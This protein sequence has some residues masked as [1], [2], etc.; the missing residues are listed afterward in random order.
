MLG[1]HSQAKW[2][3]FFFNEEISQKSSVSMAQHYSAFVAIL[4]K[5]KTELRMR[6]GAPYC[7]HAPSVT[8]RQGENS[9]E[10]QSLQQLYRRLSTEVVRMWNSI[11]IKNISIK[12]TGVQFPI[13]AVRLH[14]KTKF[15]QWFS[16]LGLPWKL[17]R[18][19]LCAS[20]PVIFVKE[21]RE[22]CIKKSSRGIYGRQMWI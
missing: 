12:P 19:A 14:T 16:D 20:P 5:Y 15:H 4:R 10:A 7:A 8:H 13:L 17:D 21:W 2:H 9:L 1:A 22:L 18:Q 3:G 6:Y 11:L